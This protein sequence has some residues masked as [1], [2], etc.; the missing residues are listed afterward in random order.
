MFLP[1]G[2]ID[3]EKRRSDYYVSKKFDRFYLNR[4]YGQLSLFCFPSRQKM[5][6]D[7][8]PAGTIERI[9][10]DNQNT[11][12]PNMHITN[13]LPIRHSSP[14]PI[15]GMCNQDDRVFKKDL[16]RRSGNEWVPS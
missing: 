3:S 8:R 12:K 11:S 1:S 16:S 10:I 6:R 15:K 2:I 4:C 9:T 14:N 13:V 5:K 7:K